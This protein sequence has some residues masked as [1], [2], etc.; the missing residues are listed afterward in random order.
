MEQ[1]EKPLSSITRFDWIKYQWQDVTQ[2][3]DEERML[4]RGY[5]R[6]PDEQFNAMQ[7]WDAVNEEIIEI[8]EES[9]GEN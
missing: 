8:Q 3:G 2:M 7:E 4:I 1:V 6:T 5:G 9:E